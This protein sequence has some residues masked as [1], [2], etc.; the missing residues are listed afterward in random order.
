MHDALLILV[1]SGFVFSLF[2]VSAIGILYA[3]YF[4]CGCLACDIPSMQQTYV[5]VIVD[6]MPITTASYPDPL[7]ITI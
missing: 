4:R 5:D 1:E 2:Q 6:L 3:P 7:V